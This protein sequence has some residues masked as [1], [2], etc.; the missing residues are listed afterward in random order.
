MVV[1]GPTVSFKSHDPESGHC[2]YPHGTEEEAETQKGGVSNSRS[3]SHR[4]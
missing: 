2:I 4:Q 3:Y 1:H